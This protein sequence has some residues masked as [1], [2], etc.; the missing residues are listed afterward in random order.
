M[1]PHWP[2]SPERPGIWHILRK[3]GDQSGVESFTPPRSPAN[4]IT[5]MRY[6][7]RGEE[8]KRTTARKLRVPYFGKKLPHDRASQPASVSSPGEM[9][10]CGLQRNRRCSPNERTLCAA[11]CDVIVSQRLA[12][13][14]HSSEPPSLAKINEWGAEKIVVPRRPR[15]IFASK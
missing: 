8:A 9:K 2:L 14:I 7:R 15:E 3:C 11:D 10:N 6:D 4:C 5:T 12:E 1:R 13:T